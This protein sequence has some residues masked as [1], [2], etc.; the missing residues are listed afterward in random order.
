MPKIR[1]KR[2]QTTS[3]SISP[4]MRKKG[5]KEGHLTH[6]HS[7]QPAM[8]SVLLA[9][10]PLVSSAG[11]KTADSCLQQQLPETL[12]FPAQHAKAIKRLHCSVASDSNDTGWHTMYRPGSSSSSKINHQQNVQQQQQPDASQLEHSHHPECSY[13]TE[14]SSC[15]ILQVKLTAQERLSEGSVAISTEWQPPAAAG[16]PQQQPAQRQPLL[17]HTGVQ[18]IPP[19][20]QTIPDQDSCHNADSTILQGVAL[21]AWQPSGAVLGLFLAGNS[22]SNDIINISDCTAGVMG[23]QQ[24][25]DHQQQQ[26]QQQTP[27]PGR[28][29]ALCLGLQGKQVLGVHSCYRD[30]DWALLQLSLIRFCEG[31]N[32][33]CSS[34]TALASGNSIYQQALL[35]GQQQCGQSLKQTLQQQQ[36]PSEQTEAEQQQQQ[37]Q[38]D[39]GA[40]GEGNPDEVAAETVAWVQRTGGDLATLEPADMDDEDTGQ[41]LVLCC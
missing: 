8:Y 13:G 18:S 12:R 25:E 27:G 14:S 11:Q 2:G 23:W 36:Q 30:P 9:E 34:S 40:L 3:M 39:E 21:L 20:R 7:L 1:E 26:T 28:T 19:Q 22:S 35:H 15:S 32:G 24:L 29:P 6:E 5:S 17:L 37:R 10:G 31:S 16:Q 41:Q 4:W 38:D 33:S